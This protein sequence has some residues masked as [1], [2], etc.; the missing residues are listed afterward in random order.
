MS[1]ARDPLLL[2]ASA[3]ADLQYVTDLRIPAAIEVRAAIRIAFALQRLVVLIQAL[4]GSGDVLLVA[5][6]VILG[7][8]RHI[9]VFSSSSGWLR[10]G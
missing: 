1:D 8:R 4:A 6:L 5:R 2:R 3:D 9:L 7:E 10:L